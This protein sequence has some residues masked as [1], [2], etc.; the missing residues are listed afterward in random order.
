MRSVDEVVEI[1]VFIPSMPDK[2]QHHV[3]SRGQKPVFYR[4]EGLRDKGPGKTA[5]VDAFE[6]ILVGLYLTL[7]QPAD[8]NAPCLVRH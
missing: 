1:G 7:Q 5:W 3:I 8:G 4:P 6:K 2:G